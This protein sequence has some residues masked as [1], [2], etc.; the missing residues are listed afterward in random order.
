MKMII[1]YFKRN[2][3]AV[4]FFGIIYFIENFDVMTYKN[5]I[6]SAVFQ[7]VSYAFVVILIYFLCL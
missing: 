2:P 1:R 4:P 6:K 5:A 3:E 7:G